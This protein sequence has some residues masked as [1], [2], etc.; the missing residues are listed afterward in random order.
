MATR[1]PNYLTFYGVIRRN[2]SRSI[3]TSQDS[4]NTEN[5][6]VDEETF[7]PGSPFSNGS[8]D[9]VALQRRRQVGQS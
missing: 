2:P 7:C 9:Q 3:A 8:K 1:H 6:D 5:L 4:G